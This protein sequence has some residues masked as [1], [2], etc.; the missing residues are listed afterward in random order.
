MRTHIRVVTI[1]VA[2]LALLSP[3]GA[4]AQQCSVFK[5]IYDSRMADFSAFKGAYDDG[6]DEYQ[7]TIRLPGATECVIKTFNDPKDDFHN[8]SYACDWVFNDDALSQ[9]E[10]IRADI[11]QSALSCIPPSDVRRAPREI[12]SSKSQIF[13]AIYVDLKDGFKLRLSTRMHK[14]KNNGK[15]TYRLNLQLEGIQ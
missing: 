7:A 6:I 14:N 11:L 9:L 15:I 2:A 12:S 13:P 8:S 4:V 3:D 5:K 1:V 10:S